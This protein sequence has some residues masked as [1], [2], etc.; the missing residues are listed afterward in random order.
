MVYGTSFWQEDA[1]L[2]T[3][4]PPHKEIGV[5][6]SLVVMVKNKLVKTHGC[7]T[8]YDADRTGQEIVVHRMLLE[9]ALAKCPSTHSDTPPQ[10][11]LSDI[12]G[13]ESQHNSLN[14]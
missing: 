12:L 6:G 7:D 4:P 10:T 3:A 1:S 14:L 5:E 9:I 11:P 13:S 2:V 8:D